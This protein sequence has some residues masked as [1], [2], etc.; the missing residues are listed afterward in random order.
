VAASEALHRFPLRSGKLVKF[1]DSIVTVLLAIVGVAVIAVLVSKQAQT[2]S[3]L[4]AGG[5]AFAQSLGCALSPVT[6]GS[7]GTSITSSISFQ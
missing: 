2:G 3:V 4:G 5:S 6:G 7:C 1:A